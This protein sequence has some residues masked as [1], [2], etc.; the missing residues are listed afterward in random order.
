M[1]TISLNII[2]Q[3]FIQTRNPYKSIMCNFKKFGIEHFTYNEQRCGKCFFLYIQYCKTLR[4]SCDIK[5][6]KF[7]VSTSNSEA[8]LWNNFKIRLKR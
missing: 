5:T 6:D 7:S 8:T 4:S 3:L 1:N 2:S